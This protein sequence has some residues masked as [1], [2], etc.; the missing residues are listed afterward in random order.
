MPRTR[1]RV[2]SVLGVG[3]AVV[4]EAKDVAAF[5]TG[6]QNFLIDDVADGRADENPK[7]HRQRVL[8]IVGRSTLSTCVLRNGVKRSTESTKLLISSKSFYGTSLV[9]EMPLTGYDAARILRGV[10]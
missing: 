4:D 2:A 5:G 10:S 3:Q 6:G 9:V 1:G 8:S 7:Q